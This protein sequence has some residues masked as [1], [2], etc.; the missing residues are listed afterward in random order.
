M[1]YILH[2]R[3]ADSQDRIKTAVI[4]YAADILEFHI[5][6][7]DDGSAAHGYA[8]E[9]DTRIF[10]HRIDLVDP[11][12][13]IHAGMLRETQIFAFGFAMCSVVDQQ[14]CCTTV[15]I[16]LYF[17]RKVRIDVRLIAM[18]TDHDFFRI[19][20]KKI[21]YKLVSVKRHRLQSF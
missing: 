4:D 12:G 14:D 6:T 9:V 7:M 17:I 18:N 19:A 16:D 15:L 10:I 8:M 5:G 13:N 1:V 3:L 11:A 21:G 2:Q 20:F